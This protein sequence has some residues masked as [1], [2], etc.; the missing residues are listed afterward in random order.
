MSEVDQLH[1]ARSLTPPYLG[2]PLPQSNITN[3]LYRSRPLQPITV[4]QSIAPPTTSSK[5]QQPLFLPDSD[6][7]Q[8]PS[9][10]KRTPLFL[11]EEDEQ[12]RRKK[13]RIS[14]KAI[15]PRTLDDLWGPRE[16]S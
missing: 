11:P 3:R 6:G 15:Q 1:A 2:P 13:R 16:V 8:V 4:K 10:S 7:E 14:S 12:P 5:E 9:V